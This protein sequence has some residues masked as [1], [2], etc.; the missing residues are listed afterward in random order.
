MG[1]FRKYSPVDK[2]FKNCIWQYLKELT[3][4]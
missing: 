1:T 3:Y 4:L 2:E